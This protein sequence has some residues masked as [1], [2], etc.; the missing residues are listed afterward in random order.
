MFTLDKPVTPCKVLYMVDLEAQKQAREQLREQGY[1]LHALQAQV[2][3]CKAE[4]RDTVWAASFVGLTEV[5]IA[6]LAGIS[7]PTVR[8]WKLRKT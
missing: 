1:R 8:D 7:R 2:D 6:E 4:L 5:E 3:Q